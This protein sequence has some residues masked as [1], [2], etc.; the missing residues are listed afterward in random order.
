VLSERAYFT[1]PLADGTLVLTPLR[2]FVVEPGNRYGGARVSET[3]SAP[4][5][6]ISPVHS[7]ALPDV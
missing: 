7:G 4:A 1:Q 2:A 3:Y 6:S 5:R